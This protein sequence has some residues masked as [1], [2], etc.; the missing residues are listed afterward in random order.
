M[1]VCDPRKSFRLSKDVLSFGLSKRGGYI[2]S[3]L[4]KKYVLAKKKRKTQI[5]CLSHN[6]EFLLAKKI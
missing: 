2:G 5:V 6:M 4:G 3:I 1:S